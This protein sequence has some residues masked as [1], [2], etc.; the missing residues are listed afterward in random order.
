MKSTGGLLAERPWNSY[1]IKLSLNGR[2]SRGF[3]PRG[4]GTKIY[5]QAV[6]SG[7][8][9]DSV[10]VNGPVFTVERVARELV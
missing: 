3:N 10:G 7:K 9:L 2:D 6:L 8:L 1:E 5:R 4:D